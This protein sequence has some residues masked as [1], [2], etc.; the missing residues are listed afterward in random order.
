V[1][2]PN[3]TTFKV[4][5]FDKDGNRVSGAFSWSARGY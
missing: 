2:A 1:D 3:P 4:L 5:L